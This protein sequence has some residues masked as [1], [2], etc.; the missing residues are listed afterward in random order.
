MLTKIC[1]KCKLE[2]SVTEFHN[3]KHKKG[4]KSSACSECNIKRTTLYGQTHKEAKRFNAIKSN[5]GLTKEQYYR[6][7]AKQDHRCAICK[8]FIEDNL[9]I[10]HC[11]KTG[12]IRGLLCKKC[13][14]GLGHFYDSS[15]LLS[16]AIHY[17]ANNFSL[18]EQLNHKTFQK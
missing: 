3:D 4:G 5:T 14:L 9:C 17:L 16:N 2:K 7:M 11:H 6:I 18:E 8:R 1:T 12:I 13:N 15:E 10:D